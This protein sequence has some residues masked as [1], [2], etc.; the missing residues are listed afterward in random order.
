MIFAF[1]AA[2]ILISRKISS[3]HQSMYQAYDAV[4]RFVHETIR[5][6]FKT[7]LNREAVFVAPVNILQPGATFIW[8]ESY[9]D[10][11]PR[12]E[13]APPLP[14]APERVLD[15]QWNPDLPKY[16]LGN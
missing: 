3:T 6:T 10:F 11:K 14:K 12:S 16:S 4:T 2:N 9:Q 1:A 7:D 15:P 13:E 8:V 5:L